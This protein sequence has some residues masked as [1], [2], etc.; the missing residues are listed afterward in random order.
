MIRNKLKPQRSK[1]LTDQ[2][3]EAIVRILDGWSGKITWELLIEEIK[4]RLH[5]TYTR[6][7]LFSH[8]R[9]RI[10]F[11]LKKDSLPFHK[12][13]LKKLYDPEEIIESQRNAR[14][15][16]ENTRLERENQRLLEQFTRWAYNAHTYGL[17]E[18][19]LN[20]ALPM[21]HR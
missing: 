12:E 1:N 14:L 15:V 19:Q 2:S 17:S 21:V 7:A 18:D 11:Q 13:K 20:K 16:A 8:E 4:K 5:Q 10:A 6:Q 3:I 9:I